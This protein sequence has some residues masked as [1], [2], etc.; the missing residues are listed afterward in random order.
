VV[1]INEQWTQRRAKFIQEIEAFNGMEHGELEYV[2]T[3]PDKTVRRPFYDFTVLGGGMPNWAESLEEMFDEDNSVAHPIDLYERKMIME[4]LRLR[5][6]GAGYSC[7]ICDFGCSTGFMLREIQKGIPNSILA[8]VD[9]IDS[10]LRKLHTYNPE[11]VLFKCDITAI[12]FPSKILDVV[13][14]LN[15]LEHISDDEKVLRE[16]YR[17]LGDQGTACIVVP[18]GKKLYDYYDKGCMHVRRYGRGGT[19][20]KGEKRGVQC[21]ETRIFVSHDVHSVFL[22]KKTESIAVQEYN[23]R[24][25]YRQNGGSRRVHKSKSHCSQRFFVGLQLVFHWDPF[26]DSG[27]R[28]AEK[29]RM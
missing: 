15:V 3:M 1:F 23:T 18:Y 17:I 16:F 28:V 27:S 8:G 25:D 12:P 19:C 20:R 5:Q 14:C 6:G 9:I 21:R 7:V 11:T 22:Q 10:G 2:R 4:F 13:L 29:I 24:K 26:W